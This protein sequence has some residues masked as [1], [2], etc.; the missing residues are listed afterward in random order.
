[1]LDRDEHMTITTTK[2]QG[3]VYLPN[4]RVPINGRVIF[5]L[6]SWDK[7][8]GEAI[9]VSGPFIAD[10]DVD[11]KIDIDLFTS[12]VGEN[13]ISYRMSIQHDDP[14]LPTFTFNKQKI[15]YVGF[16][17]SWYGSIQTIRSKHQF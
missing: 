3:T 7:E 16:C 13:N 17:F 10:I 11:G 4:G 1:M 14:T 6:T 12:T 15:E 5:E 9:F 8:V 2:V